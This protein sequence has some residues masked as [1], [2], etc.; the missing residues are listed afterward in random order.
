M[1]NFINSETKYS[2][3]LL[4]TKIVQD[5][6]NIYVNKT[7]NECECVKYPCLKSVTPSSSFIDIPMCE[8]TNLKACYLTGCKDLL[9]C[10]SRYNSKML[11][12]DQISNI[13]DVETLNNNNIN[14]NVY[15]N[16]KLFKKFDEYTQY[17]NKYGIEINLPLFVTIFMVVFIVY[18]IVYNCFT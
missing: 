16:R 7:L 6:A 10:K 17:V 11:T 4:D 3:Y 14:S 9:V 13:C 1:D 8:P 18:K 2:C 5:N 12:C 15:N